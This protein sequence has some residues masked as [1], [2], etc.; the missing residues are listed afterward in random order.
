MC[1][2]T[3]SK[4][5]LLSIRKGVINTIELKPFTPDNWNE[6]KRLNVVRK[7]KHG[8]RG[9]KRLRRRIFSI[10]T[11]QSPSQQF[12]GKK[13]ATKTINPH[14]LIHVKKVQ[15]KFSFGKVCLF[16]TPNLL[17]AVEKLPQ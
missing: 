8:R 14:N 5:T 2:L 13:S 7:T 11:D 15:F 4:D 16:G 6:L 10:V 3:Y 1:R 12:L 9:G 17:E